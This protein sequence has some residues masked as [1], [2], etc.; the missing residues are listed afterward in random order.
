MTRCTSLS[1]G[2]RF[3]PERVSGHAIGVELDAA[4]ADLARE[5]VG[6]VRGCWQPCKISDARLDG[7]QAYVASV[8]IGKRLYNPSGSFRS[9]ET[10][11]LFAAG[12]G[13]A[14]LT[15]GETSFEAGAGDEHP[16]AERLAPLLP[17]LC[18]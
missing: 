16:G 5:I 7:S 14:P 10:L 13:D 12:V 1:S 11:P 9:P 4:I 8:R 17:C 6:D 18:G 3:Q 2:E 15:D